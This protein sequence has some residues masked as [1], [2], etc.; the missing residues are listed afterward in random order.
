MPL[1]GHNP[2]PSAQI[3][4]SGTAPLSKDQKAFNG[5]IKKLDA[6]RARLKEWAT[7][8]PL[9]R[10]KYG[11]DLVPLQQQ[12]LDRQWQLAQALDDAHGRKGTTQGEKRKL[13]AL[14]VD[15]TETLLIHREDGDLK[16]LY[17]RHSRSDFDED[18]AARQEG[19]KVLLE[20]MLGMDLGNDVDMSS[21]E[22]I[23]KR[24]ESEFHARQAKYQESE[25]PRRKSRR[26]E[27]QAA[28]QEAEEKQLSQ[29][30][31]EVYRK[32]ASSLH[33][34]RESDPDEKARKTALMQRA[35][36]AYESGNLLQL[37]E[38]QLELEHIDQAHLNAIRPERLKHYVKI[39]KGQLQELDMEIER[40]E[41]E[42]MFEF[43]LDP[44]APLDPKGL[45]PIL[46][47]DMATCRR[48]IAALHEQLAAA[49][50][51]KQLKAWLKGL[52]L[53]ARSQRSSACPF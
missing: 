11:S 47:Q 52:S 1:F 19:V 46:Q 26:E 48:H 2:T 21:A 13:A 34:D 42:L 25:A 9:F 41:E 32:L 33:P 20:S 30:I 12:C 49:A 43:G 31:R 18:E 16:E 10:Q 50:D 45:I 22:D 35:N 27:A 37:L 38:L 23:M 53:R 29:S 7:I 39:L 3:V 44:F 36:T 14:I 6:R 17:N 40:V 28:R 5:L 24:V 8:L 4:P 51:A 15:L